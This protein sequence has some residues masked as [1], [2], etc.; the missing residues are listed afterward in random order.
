MYDMVWQSLAESEKKRRQREKKSCQ[1]S[2]KVLKHRLLLNHN[3]TIS[4]LSLQNTEKKDR[5]KEA[6]LNKAEPPDTFP[7]SDLCT[8]TV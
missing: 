4:T 5:D 2:Q 6:G 3:V 7:V 8:S 1:K